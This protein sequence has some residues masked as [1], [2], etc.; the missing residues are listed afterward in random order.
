[1]SR[2]YTGKLNAGAKAAAASPAARILLPIFACL[3]ILTPGLP[4]SAQDVITVAKDGSGDYATIQQAINRAAEHA[5][6]RIGAGEWTE[7]ITI[8]KPVTLEGAGWLQTRLIGDIKPEANPEDIQALQKILSELESDESRQEV[9]AAFH[10][11]YGTLPT[12]TIRDASSVVLREIAV[13]R[14]ATVRAG[15]FKETAAIRVQDAEATMDACAVLDSPGQGIAIS[16]NSNV[17]VR[18]CLIANSWGQGIQIAV[19]AEGSVKITDSDIRNCV[20]SGVSI[21]GDGRSTIQSCR[22]HGTGWHGIRYDTSSPVVT[23]NLIYDTAVSGIYASGRTSA[24]IRNNLFYL[25][26]I[27]C[28]FQNADTIESNTFIGDR[29]TESIGGLTTGVA[30]LGA[31]TPMI[32]NNLFVNCQSAI[33]LGDIG[34]DSPLAKS[35]G[36]VNLVN[37][38][39]WNNERDIAQSV[40][41]DNGSTTKTL[42]L[43]DGNKLQE[44][45]FVDAAHRDF[46]LVDNSELQRDGIGATD[47]VTFESSWPTQPEEQRAIRQVNVRKAQTAGQR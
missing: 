12:V 36:R 28:W 23:G 47:V 10:R 43:P 40:P 6:I 16:G 26:G 11:A 39:F 5:V 13:L 42:L 2:Q 46:S 4:I 24:T 38:R 31:S 8:N 1:M 45:Q 25:S 37:N 34:S 19:T 22:I 44:P 27:S 21:K 41:N 14:P 35:T 32:R 9:L 3:P 7:L 33:Y 17:V 15:R 30:V 18:S 29:E 20:Y